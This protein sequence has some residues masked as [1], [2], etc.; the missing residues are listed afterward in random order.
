MTEQKSLPE[1]IDLFILCGEQ[2]G[3]FLA[4]HFLKQLLALHP[5]LKIEGIFGSHVASLGFQSMIPFERFGQMGFTKVALSFLTILRN[6]RLIKKRI[7]QSK[8]KVVLLVDFQ[9]FNLQM[10]KKLRK[11]GYGGTIAQLV[12]PT[13]WAWKAGRAAQMA[14][15]HDLLGV[16]FPFESPLFERHGL[17]TYYIGH[18]LAQIDHSYP[19]AQKKIISLFPGSRPHVIEANLPSQLQ[20]A[21]KHPYPIGISIANPQTAPLIRAIVDKEHASH[22]VFFY[23]HEEKKL[24]FSQSLLA[25]S[26]LGTITLELALAKIPT[27]TTYKISSLEYRLGRYLFQIVLPHYCIVNILF[28]KRIFPELIGPHVTEKNIFNSISSLL[29]RQEKKSELALLTSHLSSPLGEKAF[30]DQ[31]LQAILNPIRYTGPR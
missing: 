10:A 11:N 16:L 3:D 28:K 1:K 4:S 5:S 18:P 12:A 19:A 9:S 24:L 13:V 22:R 20:A 15:T 30:L 2:S 17:K 25:I 29:N 31:I 14:K 27:I 7:L 6:F 26:T 8:P 23:P 21:L